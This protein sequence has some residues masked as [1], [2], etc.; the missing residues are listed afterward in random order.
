MTVA[1]PERFYGLWYTQYRHH[2][3]FAKRARLFA[4]F[5]GPILVVGAGFGYLVE[6]LLQ[7]REAYG[8]DASE[9]AVGQAEGRVIVADILRD[10]EHVQGRLGAFATVITEDLLPSLTDEE[11][12]IASVNCAQLGSIVIH[13]VTEQGTVSELNY[14]STGYWMNLTN[15]LTV[16]LEGM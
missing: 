6:E 3:G 12:V 13:L 7:Y 4:A 16:S 11:A 14:H 8:I 9:W 1:T 15:Q 10:V 2:E 5:P